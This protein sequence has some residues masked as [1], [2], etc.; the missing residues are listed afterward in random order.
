MRAFEDGIGQVLWPERREKDAEL[1]DKLPCKIDGITA[2]SLL[3]IPRG[4]LPDFL[5]DVA[6]PLRDELP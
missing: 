3:I 5:V 2:R 1:G 6:E 4:F